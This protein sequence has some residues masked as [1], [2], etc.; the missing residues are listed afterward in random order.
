MESQLKNCLLQTSLWPGLCRNFLRDVGGP[1]PQHTVSSLGRYLGL[2]KKLNVSLGASQQAAF[3]NGSCFCSC[4]T[5]CPDFSQWWTVIRMEKA[6]TILS[7]FWSECLIIAT[8]TRP[9]QVYVIYMEGNII[10]EY[11][12][13]FSFVCVIV[14]ICLYVCVHKPG[15]ASG[16]CQPSSSITLHVIFKTGLFP[17]LRAH[18]ANPDDQQAQGIFPSSPPWCWN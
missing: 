7:L 9:V 18:T 1:S 11:H 16:Q 3:L 6:K 14:Y 5:F 13:S 15:E 4:L 10:M 8:E 17:E 12:V 2:Y